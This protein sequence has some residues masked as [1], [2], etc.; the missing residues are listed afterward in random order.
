MPSSLLSLI[1][2][3]QLF[4]SGASPASI[5]SQGVQ[6][7]YSSNIEATQTRLLWGLIDPELSLWFA[8]PS[9]AQDR[10]SPILWDWSLRTFFA[11]LFGHPTIK[12]DTGHAIFL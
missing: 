10:D 12:E 5:L 2:S 9:V 3:L 6:L 11:T 7:S 4:F 1:L 8:Q